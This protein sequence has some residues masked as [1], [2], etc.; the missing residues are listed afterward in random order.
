MRDDLNLLVA[1]LI[2]GL[3]CA[4]GG[5]QTIDSGR[6][7]LRLWPLRVRRP[8]IPDMLLQL[9]QRRLVRLD[10]GLLEAAEQRLQQ[11]KG[12]EQQLL[13]RNSAIEPVG[14]GAGGCLVT[15]LVDCLPRA[16]P[17]LVS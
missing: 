8:R 16:D 11:R 7:Q 2:F 12:L 4:D 1:V 14:V 10:I 3:E 13:K 5:L 6:V 17:R 9:Q 15:R